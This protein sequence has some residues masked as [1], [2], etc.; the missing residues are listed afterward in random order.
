MTLGKLIELQSNG[1]LNIKYDKDTNTA[2][3]GGV[4]ISNEQAEKLCEQFGWKEHHLNAFETIDKTNKLATALKKSAIGKE[5]SDEM[6]NTTNIELQ[7]IRSITYGKTYDRI[8]LDKAD[9]YRYT[10]IHGMEN[11]GAAY[12][13]YRDGNTTPVFKGRNLGKVAEY[14]VN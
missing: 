14:I 4:V 11:I 3:L 8:V 6:L 13:L 1:V 12:V 2:S 7:N 10:I 5:W 9:A